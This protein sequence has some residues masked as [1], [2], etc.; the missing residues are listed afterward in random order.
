MQSDRAEEL[1]AEQQI[2]DTVYA[3]LAQVRADAAE[4]DQEGHNRARSGPVGG[5]VERDAMVH[6]ADRR[7]KGLDA[8]YEGL[9]FGRLDLDDQSGFH[10]GR[11]GLRDEHLEPL[12]VDWRA[13]AAAAFYQATPGVPLGVVRRRVITCAGPRVLEVDDEL[14]A[15]QAPE[16]LRLVGE[17]ALMAALERSRGSAMRDIVA[18]IQ[19][20]QDAAIRA[21]SGGVTEITGGP[22]TGK[23]QVALHRAAYLLYAERRRFAERGVLVVGPSAVFTR[24]IGQVLPGLGEDDV[25]LAALGDLAEPVAATRYDAPALAALKGDTRIVDPLAELAWQAPPDTPVRLRVSHVGRALTLGESEL[26]AVRRAVRARGVAP[27]AARGLA[28]VELLRALWVRLRAEETGP[29]TE[30]REFLDDV[31][32]RGEFRDFVEE[33]W[34]PLSPTWVLSWLAD[35]ARGEAAG[36]TAAEAALLAGSFADCVVPPDVEEPEPAPWTVSDVPLLDELRVLLGVTPE[37]K[38]SRTEPLWALQE[39]RTWAERSQEGG[40]VLSRGLDNGW[41][42]Y[43]AGDPMP[44]ARHPDLDDAPVVAQRW[45][46]A[47]LASLDL[48]VLEWADAVDPYGEPG[49]APVIK[50]AAP[51]REKEAVDGDDGYAHVIVDEAQDLSPMQ[52]RMLGRRGEYASWTVVGDPAQSSWADPTAARAAMELAMGPGARHRFA[53]R[54]NYRNSTEIFA[55]A[56]RVIAGVVPAEELPVAVRATGREPVLRAISADTL[57]EE[58][59]RAAAELLAEVT[60]TVAVIAAE[61]RLDHLAGALG[62]LADG[63]LTVHGALEAKGLEFDATV[64]VEPAELLAESGSGPR[65]LYVALTRATNR[66]TVLQTGSGWLPAV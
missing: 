49:F 30:Y 23:T 13:P 22:G 44:F 41:G 16:H 39:L 31:A 18:T 5:L 3:R 21:P 58:A 4:V 48:K 20:E 57:A 63:R 37:R 52:W 53:L 43:G 29:P 66:L 24:Y 62:G 42:L 14:L 15:A 2:V 6:L 32:D 7:M 26:A 38:G 51:A 25:R 56:T 33:W 35:P 28:A 34:P 12:L 27:N 61:H 60:G 19:G 50:G 59:V 1:A 40:Y 36:L 9:V 17:G 8:A 65:T 55:L 10:L 45:A 47:V 46:E 54:T 11:L 64:V